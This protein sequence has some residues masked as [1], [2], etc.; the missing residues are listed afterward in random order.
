MFSQLSQIIQR[1]KS[2]IPFNIREH[3]L[4]VT[5]LE[6]Q[7]RKTLLNVAKNDVK[8]MK[9]VDFIGTILIQKA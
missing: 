2:T 9:T 5:S 4:M 1:L 8:K 3:V 6:V 7:R